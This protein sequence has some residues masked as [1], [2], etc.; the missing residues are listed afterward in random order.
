MKKLDSIRF[1][2]K[3]ANEAF[4]ALTGESPVRSSEVVVLRREQSKRV[5]PMI[6]GLLDAWEQLPNDVKHDDDLTSV[7]EHIERIDA[8]MEGQQHNAQT[9]GK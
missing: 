7:R 1:K 2:G 5:M 8:A 6:G 3:A 9:T 4:K